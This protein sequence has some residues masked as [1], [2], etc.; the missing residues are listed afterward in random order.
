MN[1]P[2]AW[3]NPWL[4]APLT[5]RPGLR[6][7]RRREDIVRSVVHGFQIAGILALH[8]RTEAIG[9]VFGIVQLGEPVRDFAAADEQ[10]E[11]VGDFRTF[12]V[13]ARQR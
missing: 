11:A 2:R 3:L 12:V 8:L 7:N 1:L 5:P 10:L 6:S 4:N 9:L 13:A